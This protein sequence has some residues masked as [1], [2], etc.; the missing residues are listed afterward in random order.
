M[1]YELTSP[2]I[3]VT[4]NSRPKYWPVL[5]AAWMLVSAAVSLAL[6]YWY[7]FMFAPA[8]GFEKAVLAGIGLIAL[9][10]GGRND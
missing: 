5:S 9:S 4:F 6:L 7:A 1:S 3:D 8:I 10:T 2:F